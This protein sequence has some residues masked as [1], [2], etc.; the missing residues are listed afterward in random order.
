MLCFAYHTDETDGA[1]IA[2]QR[3]IADL[4]YAMIHINKT[5]E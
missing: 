2:G 5:Q 3:R 1:I 4:A